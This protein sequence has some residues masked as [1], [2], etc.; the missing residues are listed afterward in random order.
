MGKVKSKT[1]FL[2]VKFAKA[3]QFIKMEGM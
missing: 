2:Q 1:T 3:P